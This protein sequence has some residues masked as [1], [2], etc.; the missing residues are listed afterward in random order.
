LRMGDRVM[1][2]RRRLGV[3]GGPDRLVVEALLLRLLGLVVGGARLGG[4]PLL[5]EEDGLGEP[6]DVAAGLSEAPVLSLGRDDVPLGDVTLDERL[7]RLD[8]EGVGG[9]LE[10]PAGA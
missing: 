2:E 5:A 3:E 7:R 8:V 9:A 6:G 1:V 4:G 10:L